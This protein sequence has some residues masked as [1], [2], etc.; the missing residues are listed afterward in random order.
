MRCA[1]VTGRQYHLADYYGA[2]D[3]TDIIICMGSSTGVVEETVDWLNTHGYKTGVVKLRLFRPFPARQLLEAIPA[4]VKRIAV[5]DRTKEPGSSGEPLYLDVAAAVLDAGRPIKVIGGRYG[6][7]SKEFNPVMVKAVFDNLMSE[8]PIKGF[9]VGIDDDVTHLSLDI[10]GAHF[11]V[12]APG[13]TQAIFYGMGSDGTVGATRQIADCV[14]SVAPLYAQA[15]FNYSAKKSG[16]YTISQLRFAPAPIKEAYSIIDADYV[17]CNKNTYA[18][19]RD[20]RQHKA[21][22]HLRAQL[23]LERRG[24]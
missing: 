7:S 5:L 21:G 11:I 1:S 16:G 19:L 14:S 4:S 15:F 12:P 8:H 9:T 10:S 24:A 13:M 3:A 17:G 6:L 2:S 22:R 23:A 18:P 20:A